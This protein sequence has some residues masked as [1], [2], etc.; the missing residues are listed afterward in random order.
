MKEKEI[1][2]N[3]LLEAVWINR[4]T[5]NKEALYAVLKTEEAFQIVQNIYDELDKIG[6]KIVK[7]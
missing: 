5:E 1:I 6:Y 2:E 7:K 4:W 3:A